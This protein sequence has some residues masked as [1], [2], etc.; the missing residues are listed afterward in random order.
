MQVRREEE[1]NER[2]LKSRLYTQTIKKFTLKWTFPKH[3][4]Q[5]RFI[6]FCCV[7]S[8]HVC[9]CRACFVF[10]GMW[11]GYQMTKQRQRKVK[12]CDLLNTNLQLLLQEI[13]FPSRKITN[14]WTSN[15]HIYLLPSGSFWQSCSRM[16]LNRSGLLHPSRQTGVH[17]AVFCP[18]YSHGKARFHNL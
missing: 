4:H 15:L 10:M 3:D 14:L 12:E 7:S 8:I 6:L 17:L 11:L 1:W 18:L 2:G 16:V 9:I 5:M 13:H